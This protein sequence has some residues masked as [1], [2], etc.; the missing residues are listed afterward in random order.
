MDENAI[1]RVID[2]KWVMCGMVVLSMVLAHGFVRPQ[3]VSN[4]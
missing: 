2:D 1:L 3:M 4:L